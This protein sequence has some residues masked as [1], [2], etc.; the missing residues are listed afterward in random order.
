MMWTP[1]K[2]W[3]HSTFTNKNGDPLFL[4]PV[5]EALGYG[6]IS[7]PQRFPDDPHDIENGIQYRHQ[8]STTTELTGVTSGR[9]IISTPFTVANMYNIASIRLARSFVE[10]T[11]TYNEEFGASE[12]A[13]L[14]SL[15]K[16]LTESQI[17]SLYEIMEET[18]NTNN[19][20]LTVGSDED[21]IQRMDRLEN[22]I[23]KDKF[24]QNLLTL[25]FDNPNLNTP[26]AFADLKYWRK[27]YPQTYLIA[28]NTDNPVTARHIA[29]CGADSV[30]I[31]IGP[32]AMCTTR[33]TTGIGVPQATA[34]AAAVSALKDKNGEALAHIMADGGMRHP[35]EWVY[36]LGLGADHVMFGSVFGGYPEGFETD[37][38]LERLKMII[39]D[40]VYV[41]IYGSASREALKL[42][43]GGKN[44]WYRTPEGRKAAA[45]L[46]TASATKLLDQ[47]R[48]G[49]RSALTHRGAGSV[50]EYQ[51]TAQFLPIAGTHVDHTIHTMAI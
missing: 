6:E 50:D 1:E 47:Y 2:A 9:K 27:R 42:Y 29:K 41:P 40:R 16:Q 48:G 33:L 7:M 51:A 17:Q 26:K 44:D 12:A 4:M 13:P 35:K 23:G 22:H 14:V 37:D 8:V 20:V 10:R 34:V 39:D 43:H 28:G 49:L 15:P 19:I 31:G 38:D 24:R 11:A 45:Q 36:A 46:N 25:H 3:D 30:K 5:R 21:S 18:G 32:G